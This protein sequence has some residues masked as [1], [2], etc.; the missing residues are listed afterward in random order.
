MHRERRLIAAVTVTGG[1][2]LAVGLGLT[3]CDIVGGSV[4]TDDHTVPGTVSSVR[5]DNDSG[6]VTVRGTEDATAKT[7]SVHR[8]IR[9]R[10]DRPRGDS[11]RLADG[12]L[13]LRGCGNYCSVAYTVEVPAGVKVDGVNTSGMVHLSDVGNVDVTTSSGEV[14]LERVRGTV[15]VKTADGAITGS[16]LAAPEIDTKTS[17]G[18]IDLAVTTEPDVRAETD[19]GAIT[20]TVPNSK[21]Q[22]STESSNGS[23][24]IGVATDPAAKHRLDLSTSNGS[25]SV[26]PS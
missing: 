21:Y 6:S 14:R 25:I 23:R 24:H 7:V 20:L 18:R 16:D 8:Q 9:Y 22:V 13:T 11:Y 12:A 1:C 17:N 15:A 3:A 19:N 10:G 5:I 26:K 2:F 4:L